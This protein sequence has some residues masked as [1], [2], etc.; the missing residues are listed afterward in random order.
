MSLEKKPLPDAN[1]PPFTGGRRLM[2][3]SAAAGAGGHALT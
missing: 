1:L 3:G 2:L